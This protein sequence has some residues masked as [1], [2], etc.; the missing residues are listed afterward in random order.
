MNLP[1]RVPI[2]GHWFDVVV[3]E[4][5]LTE[6][7]DG[8]CDYQ[9]HSIHISPR[10]CEEA[11]LETLEHEMLEAANTI[12]NLELEHHQITIVGMLLFQSFE[13]KS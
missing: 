6:S 4:D 13:L 11:A 10:L 7:S 5:P 3:E 2:F 8:Y 9:T 12:A 1:A